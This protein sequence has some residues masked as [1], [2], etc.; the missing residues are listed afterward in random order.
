[1]NTMKRTGE[2]AFETVIEAHLLNHGYMSVSGEGFDRERAIFPEVVLA[3]IRDTQ[4]KEWSKL[5]ALHGDRTGEQV[6]GDLCKWM[7]VNG[8]VT[9]LRHGFKCYGR[10]LRLVF[11]KAA[12]EPEPPVGGLLRRQPAR[13]HAAT[14]LLGS[15]G[16]VARRHAES[17]RHPR[18]HRGAQKPAH[19]ADRRGRHTPVPERPG[20]PR[21]DL[22]VQATHARGTSPSIRSACA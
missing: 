12:H 22:R 20:S 7:D 9:T 16:E 19:W 21:T 15:I 2:A 14:P 8:S 17:E 4:P 18:R 5:E 6:L 13:R 10:T 11:F 3:F 1:M